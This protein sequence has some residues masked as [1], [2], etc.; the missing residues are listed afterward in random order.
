MDRAR[1]LAQSIRADCVTLE[2][3]GNGFDF[4]HHSIE[5]AARE[6]KVRTRTGIY[7]ELDELLR[8][9]YNVSD[10]VMQG[11]PV[12]IRRGPRHCKR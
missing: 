8:T 9:P 7:T 2:G 4:T 3:F 10:S 1:Q 12:K 11:K 5:A 6:H